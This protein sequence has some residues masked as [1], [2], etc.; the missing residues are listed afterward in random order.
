MFKVGNI[1]KDNCS[2]LTDFKRCMY[3]YENE[4]NFEEAWETM[5]DYYQVKE[6]RW[7][8]AIY[9]KKDMWAKCY[10]KSVYT[11]GM[12]SMRL[13]ESLNGALKVYLK[14]DLGIL[15]LFK[16]FERVVEDKRYN[17][18]KAEF[19]SR[20]KLP[21]IRMHRKP[22]PHLRGCHVQPRWRVYGNKQS[23]R[24][25][26]LCSCKKFETFGILC[27]HCLKVF[28][29]MDIKILPEQYIVKRW[30]RE[31]K[32]DI[33]HDVRG[34]VVHEDANLSATQRYRSLCS[35]L[36][37]LASKASEYD[38]TYEFVGTSINELCEK[39]QNMYVTLNK[40]N[41]ED[42]GVSPSLSKDKDTRE[43]NEPPAANV[44]LKKKVGQ[45]GRKRRVKSCLEQPKSKKMASKDKAITSQ[46]NNKDELHSIADVLFDKFKDFLN[47]NPQVSINNNPYWATTGTMT[48]DQ[49]LESNNHLLSNFHY[50][51]TK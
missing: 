39:V 28:D 9:E 14:S 43:N 46:Q 13:S 18:L 47:C 51:Q 33:V 27:S 16:N 10:M 7:L 19:D 31:A 2:L 49:G 44:S 45:K 17:E 40:L 15:H 4:E 30:T 22:S 23:L 41:S 1:K 36:V 5:S 37:K 32:Y 11:L 8:K 34:K 29:A 12:R 21:R 50:D 42:V 24:K 6:N 26:D 48:F 3:E 25:N 38:E 20:K 35:K